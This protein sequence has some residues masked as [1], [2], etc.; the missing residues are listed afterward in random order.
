MAIVYVDAIGIQ[1]EPELMDQALPRGL[2]TED[3]QD[4]AHRVG[5]CTGVIDLL[6][7]HDLLQRN[8]ICL[9]YPVLW[10]FTF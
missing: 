10:S 7:R 8:T 2:H 5:R 9:N 3:L 4:L 1:N 6:N